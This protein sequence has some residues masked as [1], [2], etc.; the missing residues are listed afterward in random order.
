MNGQTCPCESKAGL[1]RHLSDEDAETLVRLRVT[2]ITDP[3]GTPELCAWLRDAR[4]YGYTLECLASEVGLTRER[5]RQL[6]LKAPETPAAAPVVGARPEPV[7]LPW[8]DLKA[9]WLRWPRPQLS[10]AEVAELRALQ[11]Q[12][13]ELRGSHSADDPRRL[14][15]E[16]LSARLADLMENAG[17][18]YGE[19]AGALGVEPMTVRARLKRHGHRGGPAPSQKQYVGGSRSSSSPRTTKDG[20][21][22]RKAAAERRARRRRAIA[23]ASGLGRQPR[24]KRA[25]E[26]RRLSAPQRRVLLAKAR[27]REDEALREFQYILTVRALVRRGLC[28]SKAGAPLSKWGRA[29]AQ[30]AV[31]EGQGRAHV[32]HA[33][34]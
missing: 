33:A 8:P 3:A 15:S 12:A 1:I 11:N 19:L 23:E 9:S 18:T 22:A 27:G 6:V 20:D 17:F 2:S 13:R 16:Q 31:D 30:W 25:S 32:G 10:P 34:S 4:N 29:L 14:A 26:W 28:E 21:L 5:I 7:D 24:D